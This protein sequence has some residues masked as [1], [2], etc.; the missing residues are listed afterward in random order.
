MDNGMILPSALSAMSIDDRP[1][2]NIDDNNGASSS[3][4][5]AGGGG[6]GIVVG[7]QHQQQTT[8]A[9]GGGLT[10]QQHLQ[11]QQHMDHHQS[12][13][14]QQ[15]PIINPEDLSPDLLEVFNTL[16]PQQ[17]VQALEMLGQQRL[18]EQQQQQLRE[19]TL[20]IDREEEGEGDEVTGGVEEHFLTIA[21]NGT[22]YLYFLYYLLFF[23]RENER[24]M[25]G[26]GRGSDREF[27]W[28][29]DDY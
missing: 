16:D 14:Q 22:F 18:L 26:V 1:S 25:C 17:Q 20:L 21:L 13:Q 19:Q 29:E 6:G 24:E 9:M 10:E 8:D 28:W 15:I 3:S 11:Q 5:A 23:I 7:S 12:Q 2:D 4:C 27:A